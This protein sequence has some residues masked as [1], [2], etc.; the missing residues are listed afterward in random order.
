MSSDEFSKYMEYFGS[1]FEVS[2][3]TLDSSETIERMNSVL[4]S[5][6]P[7]HS[8]LPKDLL[9]VISSYWHNLEEPTMD[10]NRL[11][12][13]LTRNNAQLSQKLM[14]F[15][16]AF[17]VT[18]LV[19]LVFRPYLADFFA[20]TCFGEFSPY[21]D[22][23]VA[24]FMI[25]QMTVWIIEGSETM[26]FY[27]VHELHSYKKHSKRFLI[28]RWSY[29]KYGIVIWKPAVYFHLLWVPNAAAIVYLAIL[30]RPCSSQICKIYAFI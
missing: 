13:H 23:V 4:D 28:H 20:G 19:S 10:H 25:A 26:R 7:C 15:D 17:I 12:H 5:A 3:R 8:R 30:V 2:T 9:S 14:S 21:V 29:L 1:A 27:K 6:I 16:I 24:L 22:L 11:V 18:D